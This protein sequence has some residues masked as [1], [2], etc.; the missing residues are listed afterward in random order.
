MNAPTNLTSFTHKAENVLVPNCD[1]CF[2]DS[3][4]I[5]L[6][7]RAADASPMKRARICLHKSSEETVHE[8]LIVL[9]QGGYIRP[10]RHLNKAE[11]FHLIEGEASILIFDDDGN[12]T[13]Q[14]AL[15]KKLGAPFLY[16]IDQPVYHTQIVHSAYLVFYEVTRGPWLPHETEY[17]PWSPS[18]DPLEIKMFQQKLSEALAH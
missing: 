4:A 13:H 8:M 7:K 14:T 6:L 16:R 15:S 5:D 17:A 3:D 12:V 11:S 10:H 18:D 9:S 1:P 2:I